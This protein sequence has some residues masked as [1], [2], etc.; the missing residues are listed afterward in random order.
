VDDAGNGA[1]HRAALRTLAVHFLQFFAGSFSSLLI[2][3][4]SFPILTRTLSQ[5]DY[6]SLSI[7]TVAASFAV[8]IAKGGL[9]DSI[10]RFYPESAK[11]GSLLRTLTSTV[12]VRSILMSG[13]VAMLFVLLVTPTRHMLGLEPA[14][15]PAFFVMTV[16]VFVRP[17]N[18]VVLNYLRAAGR[19]IFYNGISLFLKVISVA[20]ALTLLFGFGG[21]LSLYFTGIALAEAIG[22]A[23]LLRWLLFNYPISLGAVSGELTMRLIRFG[24]PLLATELGYLLLQ[25]SDRYLLTAY[26]DTATLA[27]YA[28]GYNLPSYIND[29]VLFSV[30]YAIVPIYT[31]LFATRGQE[32]TKAFL[33]SALKYYVIGVVPLCAGYA[34]IAR[35]A[36][37]L[38]ASTRYAPAAAYSPIVLAGLVFIGAN[39]I[40]YAGL[41]LHKRSELILA[42]MALAVAVNISMN[43]VLIP[44]LGALGCAI[45]TL[46]ACATGSVAAAAISFRYLPIRIPWASL[47]YYSTASIVMYLLV[48]PIETGHAVTNLLLKIPAGAFIVGAAFLLRDRRELEALPRLLRRG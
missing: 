41:Y 18:I 27:T 30:S 22:T 29:L 46:V 19:T 24:L 28:V 10:I 2:G 17:L 14:I 45:S 48:S 21:R 6:G 9:S 40:L 1:H 38:L 36:I 31:E 34:A 15:A 47:L 7:V 26:T 23:I 13:T 37:V 3:L 12:L 11:E 20:L 39:Y 8:V 33:A 16:F 25:Y 32:Q 43:L 35:D 44:Q 5:S 42:T 4:I